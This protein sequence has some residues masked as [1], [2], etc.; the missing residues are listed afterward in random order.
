MLLSFSLPPYLPLSRQLPVQSPYSHC[1]LPTPVL[2]PSRS[3]RSALSGKRSGCRR[4]PFRHCALSCKWFPWGQRTAQRN[5]RS[6][7]LNT[8]QIPSCWNRGCA[9]LG[10][11]ALGNVGS[12][13]H[14]HPGS[15]RGKEEGLEFM[16]GPISIKVGA[17]SLTWVCCQAA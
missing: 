16:E 14:S 13:F 5:C 11:T 2:W 3:R 15:T 17:S 7:V 6:H 12:M 4:C 8:S 10:Y 9:G 1:C